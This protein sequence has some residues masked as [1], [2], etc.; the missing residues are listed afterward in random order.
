M[1]DSPKTVILLETVMNRCMCRRAFVYLTGR[2]FII[3]MSGTL[4]CL[5]G[6]INKITLVSLSC[7]LIYFLRQTLP[8][9]RYVARS[10]RYIET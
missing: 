4:R 9:A 1:S 8:P 6:F 3:T 5:V 10:P 2:S 7:D